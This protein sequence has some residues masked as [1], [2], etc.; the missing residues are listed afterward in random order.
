PGV[1]DRTAA[2]RALKSMATQSPQIMH[3]APDD[4]VHRN[5]QMVDINLSE[6]AGRSVVLFNISGDGTIQMLYPVG[7]DPPSP[8]SPNLLLPLRVREPFGAE[9]IV[10]VTSRQRM[11]ELEKVLQQ[12][13]RRRASGQLVKSLEQ[14]MPADARIG[15][16]GFFTAP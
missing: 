6:V 4:R 5:D 10:A 7:S 9:Q 12:V 13:N 8:R 1:I 11:V 15:S 14:Y 2:I 16:V 3:V